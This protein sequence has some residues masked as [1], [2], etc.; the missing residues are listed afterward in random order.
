MKPLIRLASVADAGQIQSIY[1]PVVR[2]TVISFEL[3]PPELDEIRRRMEDVLATLPWLVCE[4]DGL[5]LGYAYAS[6]HRARWAYQWSVDTSVYIHE[7]ARR[8]GI[9]RA[10]YTSLFKIL[11]LQGYYNAYAGIALPN[12]GSVGLHEAVG[13]RPVGVYHHVGY[14]M[15]AWHDVGWWELELQPH[16]PEPPAPQGIEET[17]QLPGWQTALKAGEKLLKP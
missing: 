10:L 7:S 12:P 8:M 14:K 16:V 13:F 6:K 11:S 2:D 3:E 17:Q 15:E 4:R 9:G 5:V 1:A